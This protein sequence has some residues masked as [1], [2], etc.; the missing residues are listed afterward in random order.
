M[1]VIRKVSRNTEPLDPNPVSGKKKVDQNPPRFYFQQGSATSC[2][3]VLHVAN[4]PKKKKSYP[5][6]RLATSMI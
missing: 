4:S 1:L 3:I 2:M 5:S 6:F